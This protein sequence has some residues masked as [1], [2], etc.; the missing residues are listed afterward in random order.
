MMDSVFNMINVNEG[1][2]HSPLKL[3]TLVEVWIEKGGLI[4]TQL[5]DFLQLQGV[6]F[7][8]HC[9]QSCSRSS[10]STGLGH[11]VLCENGNSMCGVREGQRL[12][13]VSLQPPQKIQQYLIPSHSQRHLMLASLVTSVLKKCSCWLLHW[14]NHFFSP[15][16]PFKCNYCRWAWLLGS[17]S[18]FFLVCC[19]LENMRLNHMHTR[20]SL[21]LQT[22]LWVY[23]TV[24]GFVAGWNCGSRVLLCRKPMQRRKHKGTIPDVVCCGSSNLM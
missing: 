15:L 13:R 12:S 1:C 3:T 7:F 23:F 16:N 22:T 20:Y 14:N 8:S 5:E 11:M 9:L 24:C 10:F 2:P 18:S 6:G 21:Y 19:L 17:S 4:G